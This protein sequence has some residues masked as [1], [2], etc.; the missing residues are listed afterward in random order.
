M[1]KYN[2][3]PNQ[4]KTKKIT[5]RLTESEKNQLD[6]LAFNQNKTITRVLME[7]I[8]KAS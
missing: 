1:S 5:I 7:S 2:K 6:R 3:I 4:P 8:V